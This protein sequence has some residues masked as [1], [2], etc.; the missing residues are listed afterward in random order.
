MTK[1]SKTNHPWNRQRRREYQARAEKQ[2]RDPG[3]VKTESQKRHLENRM[4][5]RDHH[6]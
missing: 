4:V 2:V 3:A 5:R 6:E 1:K